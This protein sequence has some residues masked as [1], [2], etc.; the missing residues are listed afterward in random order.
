MR[1]H[2]GTPVV[3]EQGYGLL[4]NLTLRNTAGTP[5]TWVE[6][7]E[8]SMVLLSPYL[9]ISPISGNPAMASKPYPVVSARWLQN[10]N[11]DSHKRGRL[12]SGFGSGPSWTTQTIKW[13]PWVNWCSKSIQR[14]CLRVKVAHP[15]R[16]ILRLFG[17]PDVAKSV[18]QLLWSKLT[19]TNKLWSH[20]FTPILVARRC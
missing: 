19:A 6:F 11:L 15:L 5:S 3:C 9:E 1:E 7:D 14:G 8:F 13:S 20:F 16:W 10:H 18:I 12:L 2:L 4:A 17:R